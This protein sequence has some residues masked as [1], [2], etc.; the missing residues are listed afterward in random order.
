LLQHGPWIQS[1][2]RCYLSSALIHSFWQ[3]SKTNCSR[4]APLLRT[5]PDILCE[6]LVFQIRPSQSQIQ[7][8]SSSIGFYWLRLL[9]TRSYYSFSI[10]LAGIVRSLIHRDNWNHIG[11]SNLVLSSEIGIAS[12]LP[13]DGRCSGHLVDMSSSTAWVSMA[14]L[15]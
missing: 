14:E 11:E 12:C 13:S 1:V 8:R 4:P 3:S 9:C 15:R 10:S 2:L 6:V 5:F 7:L